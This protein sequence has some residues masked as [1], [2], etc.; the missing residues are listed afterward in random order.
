[1]NY[2][3]NLKIMGNVFK[4]EAVL[5]LLPIL[6][7]LFYN[8]PFK[9]VL[10]FAIPSV[11]L[12][13]VGLAL[14]RLKP[15]KTEILPRD[16]FF[17]VSISWLLI[18]L[19]GAFP[20]MINGDI[21]NYIDAFFETASGFSTTGASI[22]VDVEVLQKSSLFW[23]SFTHW[24]GGMG[25]LVFILAIMPKDENG[26]GSSMYVLRAESPGPQVGKL[27][28]KISAS[29][30]ILYTIYISM[31]VILTLLLVI[32]P[33]IDFF[34]AI[35]LAFSTAGTGGFANLNSGIA[36]YSPYVQYV[37]AIGMMLF[38]INF[39]LYYML[40]I[41][42]WRQAFKSEELKV[43]LGIISLATIF[44]TITIFTQVNNVYHTF[45]YAFR[46]SFFQVTSII[47]TTGFFTT[48]FSSLWPSVGHVVLIGLM[49]VGAMA[50]ST[51]GGIKVARVCILTKSVVARMKKQISPRRVVTLKHEGQ[52][53]SSDVSSQVSAFFIVYILL[54]FLVA[55]IISFDG[56]DWVTNF[57]AS[58][59]CLSNVGPGFSK[60]GPIM[61]YSQ[62]SYFSKIILALEM[63][64]GRL[65]LF[66]VLALFYPRIWRKY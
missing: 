53:V 29:T 1:M 21:P 25:I 11:V 10:A 12:F 57:S 56:F 31:T 64:I 20:F 40:L 41:K 62:F 44:L 49:F 19:V 23:R 60:V 24:I 22:L 51:G 42:K 15:E 37:I 27:V 34:N 28:S 59:A 43:Y 45:E 13:L 7:A 3:N 18:S 36:L 35:C 4:V 6:I 65:E 47:T 55:F 46:T 39:T 50:G 5:M 14:R 38:G 54:I 16:A 63:I 52:V 33:K 48:D 66:P 9:N 26:D 17:I 8:E 30:Q 61:N 2:K 32:D 58:L